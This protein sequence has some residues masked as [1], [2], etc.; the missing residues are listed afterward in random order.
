M[1]IYTCPKC[2]KWAMAWDGRAKVFMCYYM[3]TCG[4]V[5]RAPG[6]RT[7][8]PAHVVFGLLRG[9]YPPKCIVHGCVN[10]QGEGTFIGELC[11][12]CHEMLVTGKIGPTTSFLGDMAKELSNARERLA[13]I[14]A[15]T[16]RLED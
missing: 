12:P 3:E 7:E 9:E 1:A 6:W 11:L 15:I 5:V 8:P 10:R 2:G 13:E 16:I 14:K 4:H